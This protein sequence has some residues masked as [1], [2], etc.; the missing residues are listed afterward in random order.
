MWYTYLFAMVFFFSTVIHSAEKETITITRDEQYRSLY[1]AALDSYEGIAK[2][3]FLQALRSS[4]FSTARHRLCVARDNTVDVLQ[5]LMMGLARKDFSANTFDVFVKQHSSRFATPQSIAIQKSAR[6]F[7]R[8][9]ENTPLNENSLED[10]DIGHVLTF[11]SNPLAAHLL[12]LCFMRCE[13]YGDTLVAVQQILFAHGASRDIATYECDKQPNS[14]PESDS[15][16]LREKR[17]PSY[18]VTMKPIFTKAIEDHSPQSVQL[19]LERGEHAR[20]NEPRYSGHSAAC[21]AVLLCNVSRVQQCDA[22]LLALLN[23]G[24][25]VNDVRPRTHE[26]HGL[27]RGYLQQNMNAHAGV[28]FNENVVRKI[29]AC[30]PTD[31]TLQEALTFLDT[32]PLSARQGIPCN[33]DQMA[34]L[35]R[36][37]LM[38][39]QGHADGCAYTDGAASEQHSL[40][41]NIQN[42]TTKQRVGNNSCSAASSKKN[43]GFLCCAVL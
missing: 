9:C 4:N 2:D 7:D 11:F 42:S 30:N 23:A 8:I 32:V 18:T 19:F 5:R 31:D 29:L 41:T 6:E 21:L 3:T 37:H 20:I 27:L 16:P 40:T 15:S 33:F 1:M 25:Q 35:V 24:A 43:K 39:A 22:V 26:W 12:N 38:P 28:S 13:S 10:R 36:L 17:I 34:R 14:V